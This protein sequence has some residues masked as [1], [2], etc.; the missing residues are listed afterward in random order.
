MILESCGLIFKGKRFVRL[1][2]FIVVCLGFLIAVTILAGL[3]IFDRQ[4][5]HILHDYVAR[6]DDIV[7][8]STTY[9]E[10][11]KSFPSN[12][13][14]ILFN[15]VQVFHLKYST[16]NVVAETMQGN[17]EVQ[18]K[19]HPVINTI[20]FFCKWVPYL[21]VGQVPEDHVLLKLS[22]NKKDGMELSLR[23]PFQT[24]RKVVACFSPLFL[25][26]RWQL[27]LAT[28]EIYSHY[29]A[30]MH[31]YV[32]SMISDLFKLI[33]ENKNSRI[34]PWPA[35]RIGESRAA[36]PMFDPN[37]ELEF[38][39]QA[40]AMTDCLLQYKESAEF[41]VFPDPDDILVPTLGKNYHEEFTQAFNMFPTAGAIV[42]NM[43]QTSIE[44]STTPALY[45]PISLLASIK[46]KGEQRWGKLVVRPERVDS[47]W[48]HRSY[49]IREGYEQKV[50]PVDV[51]AFYH[52]RIW[53]FPDFPTINRTKVSNPPYFDPYHL[54]ATKRTIYKVSDGLKIQRKFKNRV[55]EGN[56]KAIYSRL[57]KVSLYYPLI[58]V[59]YNRIFYSMKDIG[60]C[61]GPEYCNIPAFPG[62]RCTN[63]A[64]EF[65]TYKSYRNIYIHQLISTDFEEGENGCTL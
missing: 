61:R 6:N 42:Y 51:N 36:S 47:T 40:S 9:Y 25:N 16:L 13:A 60:T 28:V 11:S 62:L 31:F 5:N 37:T 35:I 4:H 17:V 33:K 27:L 49:S 24:P 64:S 48:I 63:V 1:F 3:T 20:P 14:V 58:E 46:F 41:V 59:C 57:P 52:L 34:S 2:I 10:N 32:R 15:S 8:L 18:F 30:F 21:A 7:V 23:T 53:K 29:G 45:S 43:T 55:S 50:M 65:V 26:E 12:T 54:N 44:S 39:N 19:I 38:R 56:M 22:T